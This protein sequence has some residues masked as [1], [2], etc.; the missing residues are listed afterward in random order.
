MFNL[1]PENL[2]KVIKR[3]YNLRLAI[4][5][6]LFIIFIQISSMIFLLPTWLITDY[7]EKDLQSRAD[8]IKTG[9]V[10]L[11]IASTTENIKKINNQLSIMDKV[12]QYPELIPYINSILSKKTNA[13]LINNIIYSNSDNKN[14]SIAISGISGTREALLSFVKS[15]ESSGLFK[16]VEVPIT[17]FTKDKNFDF[18][19]KITI[20]EE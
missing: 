1:L 3:E 19:L 12:L 7:K 2:R 5:V 18:S 20:S 15:L 13:I 17:N 4:I 8:F 9:Q 16:S 14:A 11:N 6:L 10:N